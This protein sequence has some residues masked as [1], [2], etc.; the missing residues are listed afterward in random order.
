MGLAGGLREPQGLCPLEQG[1]SGIFTTWVLGAGY[2]LNRDRRKRGQCP[3]C[4]TPT[5]AAS[6]L[7]GLGM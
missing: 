2:P 6:C 5:A 4:P 3:P 7:S 1:T